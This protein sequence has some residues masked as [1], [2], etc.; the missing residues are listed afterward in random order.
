MS[1]S[2]WQA[3]H[4]RQTLS[5]DVVI[6]GGGIVGCATAY[7]LHRQRPSL[8]VAIVEA[9]TLGAGASGRN[10]GF[11]LQGTA[12]DYGA[13][14]DRYG[15]RTARRL[16]HFTR[17]NRD[18]MASEL[19]GEAFGWRS[20]GSLTV[21]GDRDED[22]RLRAS[23][24]RLRAAGAPVV[25]LDPDETNDR[26]DG[27]GFYGG[28]FVTT[29]AVVDPL[30]LVRHLAAASEATV[31]THLPVEALHWDADDG[32]LLD[33]PDLRLWG[34]RAVLAVGPSLPA[35]AP[36]LS[37]YVRPVRAQMLATAPAPKRA[38]SLPVYSHQGEFYVRQLEDGEVLLGGG[39]HAHREAEATAADSTTPAV[40][41]RLERYLHTHFPWAHD[42]PIRR[43]W[44][45]TMGF[46][47]DGRP[48][49]GP[50]PNH[51]DSVFATGF[52]GHGM[53]YGFRMGRLLAARIRG[54]ER[55][56]GY[57]L[58]RASRFTETSS[59]RSA[60]TVPRPESSEA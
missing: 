15:E 8:R 24:A 49:V 35:L 20:E 30:R 1:L 27:T 51:P 58:F 26:V 25:Y 16:W 50:V 18:L 3:S 4:R 54:R 7:W 36:S 23:V 48:V 17:A 34:R 31:Y 14:V 29:G 45:G 32:V 38:I 10:A 21:A 22:E 37:D 52:T 55:P 5:Y 39:R 46:S 11:I 60:P 6:V 47:P 13:D 9:G 40:Q 56:D 43:R 19:R 33:T 42:V 41:A 12:A 57:D 28:L 44:S 59:A 2:F 53:G